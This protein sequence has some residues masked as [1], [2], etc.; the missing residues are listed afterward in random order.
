[1]EFR[2]GDILREGAGE[3]VGNGVREGLYVV[4]AGRNYGKRVHN[5]RCPTERG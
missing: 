4:A 5:Q 2:V 1:M 3:E